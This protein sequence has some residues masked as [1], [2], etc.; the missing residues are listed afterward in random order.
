[1][2]W[3]D[4][5][6]L[7]RTCPKCHLSN[8]RAPSRQIPS[9]WGTW[10]GTRK[11]GCVGMNETKTE[12]IFFPQI[13]SNLSLPTSGD[14]CEFPPHP[15]AVHSLDGAISTVPILSCSISFHG[16][17]GAWIG[18]FV[19]QELP[20]SLQLQGGQV[21]AVGLCPPGAG[22]G[23]PS[24]LVPLPPKYPNLGCLPQTQAARH[25][26]HFPRPTAVHV[27]EAKDF[28]SPFLPSNEVCLALKL[29]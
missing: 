24:W 10:I 22:A 7:I 8:A 16:Y 2:D 6:K 18:K 12:L 26:C 11:K 27:G 1:M 20:L 23:P 21:A 19:F 28:Y 25:C 13:F 4:K 9:V 3:F 17:W 15:S 14:S 5:E 29:L